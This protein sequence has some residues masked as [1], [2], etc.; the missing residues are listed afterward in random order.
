MLEM[1]I[2]QQKL[3]LRELAQ[4]LSLSDISAKNVCKLGEGNFGTV[5]V[6]VHVITCNS[7]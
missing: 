7:K 6:S 4:V 2:E 5:S 1:K 3:R